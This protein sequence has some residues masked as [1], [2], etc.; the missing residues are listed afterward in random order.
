VKCT[1]WQ[2]KLGEWEKKFTTKTGGRSVVVNHT[3]GLVVA[4]TLADTTYWLDPYLEL[5]A[6][7][8]SGD[9]YT[10]H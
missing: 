4:D 7:E 8:T 6:S 2:P 5:I 9:E 3:H 10:N 1:V